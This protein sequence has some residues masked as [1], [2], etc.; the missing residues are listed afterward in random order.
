MGPWFGYLFPKA[1][2]HR[3]NKLDRN[4]GI[5]ILPTWRLLSN[6]VLGRVVSPITC[7][8]WI[9]VQLHR[10]QNLDFQNGPWSWWLPQFAEMNSSGS[11]IP[12]GKTSMWHCLP[13]ETAVFPWVSCIF[14]ESMVTD[15]KWWNYEPPKASSC[16][17]VVGALWARTLQ[18]MPQMS[19][20]SSFSRGLN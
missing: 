12:L 8:W 2:E 11:R 14:I 9:C 3:K 4:R 15:P 13:C 5:Q 18:S 19:Q 17:D 16:E 6:A 1:W 20:D 7:I 10:N